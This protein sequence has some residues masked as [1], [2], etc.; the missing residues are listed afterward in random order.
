METERLQCCILLETFKS[1]EIVVE[2][3]TTAVLRSFG[4]QVERTRSHWPDLILWSLA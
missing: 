4:P 3:E 2:V 1:A